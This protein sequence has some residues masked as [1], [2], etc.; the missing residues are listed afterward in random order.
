MRAEVLPDQKLE[1]VQA[2]RQKHDSAAMV[3]D[4]VND[5]PALAASTVG[6]AIAVAGGNVALETTGVAARGFPGW[7]TLWPGSYRQAQTSRK[8]GLDLAGEE[9]AL[10]GTYLGTSS[11]FDVTL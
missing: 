4:G 6:I 8:I 1:T 2:L 10:N 7:L 3:G 5:A 9:S 11:A